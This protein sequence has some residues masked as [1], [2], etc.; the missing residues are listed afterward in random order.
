[1]AA[2]IS[3]RADSA[4]VMTAASEVYRTLVQP[5][6]AQLRGRRRITIVADEALAAV[7]FAALRSADGRYLIEDAEIDYAFG[8]Q[9]AVS[10]TS[11]S[12][13]PGRGVLLVGDPSFDRAGAPELQPLRQAAVEMQ[14]IGQL[15]PSARRLSGTDATPAAVLTALGSASLFQFSGHALSAGPGLRGSRLVLAPG[16]DG[17]GSLSAEA[18]AHLHLPLLRLVVLSAC[19][20]LSRPESGTYR[21]DGL[22]E[23]FLAAGARGV[24]GSLWAVD[25]QATTSLM[26][27]LHSALKAGESPG[28]ALQTAQVAAL[29]RTGPG[30]APWA[31]AAFRLVGR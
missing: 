12:E 26:T 21:P 25:D 6:D 5:V 15:Y 9:A 1:M 19:Q 11:S 18:I 10:A 7:P 24:I 22:A 30:S 23:A 3:S 20:T 14:Q 16:Q 31:W 4:A 13:P 27:G 17:A 8:V 29:R 28:K 2:L